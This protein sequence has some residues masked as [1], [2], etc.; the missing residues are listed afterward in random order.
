MTIRHRL[1]MEGTIRDSRMGL[2]RDLVEAT[3][4]ARGHDIGTRTDE[5]KGGKRRRS[6]YRREEF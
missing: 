4:S 2:I 6:I 3:I 1:T 5:Q